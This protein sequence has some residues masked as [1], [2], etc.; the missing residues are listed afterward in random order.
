[1]ILPCAQN[2]TSEENE[3]HASWH[4]YTLRCPTVSVRENTHSTSSFVALTGEYPR[5]YIP[6]N[7]WCRICCWCNKCQHEVVNVQQC[8]LLHAVCYTCITTFS[9]WYHRLWR[10]KFSYIIILYSPNEILGTPVSLT[11]ALQ[12]W[13]PCAVNVLCC[14]IRRRNEDNERMTQI[15]LC[16]IVTACANTHSGTPPPSLK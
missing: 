9:Y 14:R 12:H 6:Q 1:M 16:E 7:Y 13:S 15:V 5:G 4:G 11:S 2:I 3:G 10:L 8:S